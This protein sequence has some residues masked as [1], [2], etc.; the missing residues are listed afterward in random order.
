[1]TIPAFVASANLR[2]TT[3]STYVS[4]RIV[5]SEVSIMIEIDL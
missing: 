2:F 5:I 1:M 4:V 3:C